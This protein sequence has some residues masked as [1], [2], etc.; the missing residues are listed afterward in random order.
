MTYNNDKN[1]IFI[2]TNVLIG[3]FT[4]SKHS[5]AEKRCWKYVCSLTGKKL[6]VSSLS[7][8]QFVSVL[9]HKLGNDEVIRNVKQI[10]SKVY[11]IDFSEKDIERS[12]DIEGHDLEDNIQY[13]IS[14]KLKCGILITQNKKDYINYLNVDV[15]RAQEHRSI[16]Q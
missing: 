7:V 12:L 11:V 5:D 9:Q 10:L 13:V 2:D 1:K 3:A 14:Q 15:I 8:A 6:Y 16:N 4:P